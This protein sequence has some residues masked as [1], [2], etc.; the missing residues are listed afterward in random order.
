MAEKGNNRINIVRL[1]AVLLVLVLFSTCLVAGRLARYTA[2]AGGSDGARVAVFNITG[3]DMLTGSFAA[4]IQPGETITK[5]IIL[6][7]NS[8]VSIRYTLTVESM[9]HQLPLQLIYSQSGELN[10]NNEEKTVEL[11]IH[12]PEENNDMMY[13]GRVELLTISVDVAQLD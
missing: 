7:N 1:A 6:M 10:P 12:W 9:D 4:Q 8:E 5:S 2:L 11:E 3:E 13:S